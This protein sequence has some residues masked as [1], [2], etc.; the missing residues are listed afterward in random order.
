MDSPPNLAAA[1]TAR[2]KC[3]YG[4][5]K[6]FGRGITKQQRP[7]HLGVTLGVK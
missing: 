1:K 7:R 4:D 2:A 5:L 3:D 6:I